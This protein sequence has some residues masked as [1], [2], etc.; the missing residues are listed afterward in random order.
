M[1]K[2]VF[3]QIIYKKSGGKSSVKYVLYNS[4]TNKFGISK[5][6]QSFQNIIKKNFFKKKKND[7]KVFIFAN[8]ATN[9]YIFKITKYFT[10]SKLE[11]Y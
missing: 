4:I 1:L 6:G 7:M 10:N 8:V 2:I 3:K 9:N 5:S 11:L